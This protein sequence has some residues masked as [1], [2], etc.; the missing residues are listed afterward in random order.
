MVSF[1]I[2]SGFCFRHL[3]R[4]TL[5]RG[6]ALEPGI[7]LLALF[8]S[9][10][11]AIP[12]DDL[13]VRH[14]TT[15]ITSEAAAIKSL[16]KKRPLCAEYVQAEALV[17]RLCGN[18][19]QRQRKSAQLF[20][21]NDPEKNPRLRTK[22]A[23]SSYGEKCRRSGDYR[24]AHEKNHIAAARSNSRRQIILSFPRRARRKLTEGRG[25]DI[26]DDSKFTTKEH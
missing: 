9:P 1:S 22:A 10:L 14:A 20:L 4:P 26:V 7:S 19:F 18:Q 13:L 2:P 5:Q 17:C 3:W 24:V 12:V 21:R 15:G 23:N 6:T 8:Q 16:L 25:S 11:I